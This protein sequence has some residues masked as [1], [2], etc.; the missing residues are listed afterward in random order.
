MSG[1]PSNATEQVWQVAAARGDAVAWELLFESAY[2]Q[3][4][5]YIL[6]RAA[7]Q[8][9][10]ADEVQ[11]ETWLVAA[12]KV[13]N[14][15]A[16]RGSFFHWVCGIAANVMRNQLRSEARRHKRYAPL[17]G[18]E[19]KEEAEENQDAERVALALSQLPEHYEVALRAKYVEHLTVFELAQQLGQTP[20]AVESLLTRARQAFR[21][22]YLEL[23]ATGQ[24]VGLDHDR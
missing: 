3:V 21:E 18:G 7:R 12:R 4:A 16:T 22:M 17:Q 20:K 10:L 1:L 19:A 23:R 24:R 8:Q 11:Q 14:F 6:W 9:H 15:D 2:E 13:A 5:Q